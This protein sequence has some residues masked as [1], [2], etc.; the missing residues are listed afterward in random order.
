[1][2]RGARR[3]RK[4]H[5]RLKW[6]DDENHDVSN[7][8]LAPFVRAETTSVRSVAH[9]RALPSPRA[10]D[11]VL[12][13]HAVGGST[14]R[15]PGARLDAPPL[16][17]E[18]FTP[19][20][21]LPPRTSREPR[22]RRAAPWRPSAWTRTRTRTPTPSRKSWPCPWKAPSGASRRWRTS[23]P[24]PSVPARA[25]RLRTSTPTRRKPPSPRAPR[26]FPSTPRRR[27]CGST[28][29]H[30]SARNGAA[31]PET[32]PRTWRFPS[33]GSP[34]GARTRARARPVPRRGAGE[35]AAARTPP[36]RPGFVER[37]RLGSDEGPA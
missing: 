22:T 11:G 8:F 34:P 20:G 15:R 12:R 17:F 30:R 2:K 4:K 35:P 37:P 16:V 26:R 7:A 6:N 10:R 19:T 1:M 33:R 29:D 28:P 27:F 24:E 3:K 21:E 18:G 32:S 25:R 23:C 5:R 31:H 14:P 36:P 13:V 9:T